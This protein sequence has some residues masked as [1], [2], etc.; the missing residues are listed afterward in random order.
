MF[1]VFTVDFCRS[2]SPNTESVSITYALFDW[3]S[4]LSVG[5]R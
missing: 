3:V 2:S 4:A 5:V 1:T